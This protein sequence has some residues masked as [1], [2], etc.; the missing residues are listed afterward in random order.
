[1]GREC[2]G[3]CIKILSRFRAAKTGF[4]P[5]SC[6]FSPVGIS[7]SSSAAE[8]GYCNYVP[9]TLGDFAAVFEP[10]A[11]LTIRNDVYF[12]RAD[13]DRSVRSGQVEVDAEL[14]YLTILYK[15]DIEILGTHYAFG[16]FVPI[17]YIDIESGL[18]IGNRENRVSDD[19]FGQGDIA[20]IPGVFLWN[21]NNFHFTF[22]ELMIT[23][24]GSYDSDE[25]VNTGLNYW[26]FDTNAAATYLNPE[27]GQDY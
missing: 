1:M 19:V 6:F 9:G 17:S 25:L 10:P 4:H 8:G 13:S 27:T 15:P 5:D 3:P 26:T 11:K 23:P 18:R 7:T 14:D 16:A 2:A 20:L 12:Y 21:H 24:T 22:T